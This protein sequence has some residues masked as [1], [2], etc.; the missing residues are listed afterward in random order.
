MMQVNG[1]YFEVNK[2]HKYSVLLLVTA[3][4]RIVIK[5]VD[6]SS[7]VNQNVNVSEIDVSPRLAGTPRSITF[8]D[9][10]LFETNDN[11]AIDQW[12]KAE[13]T[14]NTLAWIHLL[15]SRLIYV[16]LTL[17][18]VL[19]FSWGFIQYGVP[20]LANVTAKMLPSDVN[21]YL[22]KG[23]LT[24]L[25][26]S[27]FTAS[28]L[29]LAH[30]TELHAQFNNYVDDYKDLN[31]KV[32][33]R[34]GGDIGANAFALPDGH[35]V[36]TDE[37]VELSENDN[38]LIAIFAHEIGHLAHRHLLRRVIQDSLLASLVVLITGDI[39]YAS[40]VIIALPAL[41]LEL[42][43]S[44]KFEEE[45]DDFALSFLNKHEIETKHFANIMLRLSDN[46]KSNEKS[47]GSDK[48]IEHLN[49][50]SSL[51]EYLSTHPVTEER[52]KPFLAQ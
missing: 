19:I 30:Q 33:F 42:A 3:D 43:Y 13:N 20:S 52:I 15:E 37:M 9:G 34:H 32:V 49:L 50:D 24:L 6:A 31:V 45:A 36:F 18:F 5:A 35:I 46:E 51:T 2:S 8:P 39:S 27:Y 29:A 22:G 44:R 23:T 26:K 4:N 7:K 47:N 41:L 14:H 28:E 25:D 11:E 21:Q 1:D 12:L 10:S 40:T 16:L 38:E 17:F 48:E